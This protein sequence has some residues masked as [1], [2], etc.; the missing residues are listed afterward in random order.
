M[1]VRR[2]LV[3]FG[4]TCT[5]YRVGDSVMDDL[6]RIL[7]NVVGAP[8]RALVALDGS[9]EQTTDDAVRRALVDIGF[10][11]FRYEAAD[12]GGLEGFDAAG[13]LLAAFAER[14]LTA[15]DLVVAVGGVRLCSV[16]SLAAGLWC[17]GMSCAAI[18]Q[19]LDAM[20]TLTT[21][22]R[23]LSVGGVDEVV[24]ARPR[25]DMVV[26]DLTRV[27]GRPVEELGAGYVTMLGTA[28]AESRR[29]WD[30]FPERIEGMVA[31]DA[32]AF[33]EALCKTQGARAG[34]I[35]S[36]SPSARTALGYGA[37]TARALAACLGPGVPW[38]RLFAEGMRFEARLGH[39]VCDLDVDVIFEQDDRLEDLGVEEVPFELDADRFVSALKADRFLRS[40]RFM[41]SLPKRPGTIRL[42][43]VDDEVL[44]RH[45]EAFLASRAELLAETG[46]G[47]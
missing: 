18:P 8:K 47:N 16:V 24:S 3:N 15:D 20:C 13:R 33:T 7:K 34:A 46:A 42:S 35:R 40:N 31:G 10:E 6:P 27:L 45:A 2:Q 21:A 25:W 22:M 39:D 37:S 38:Y 41:L 43:S 1:T 14:G 28:L 30:Q 4:T 36:A 5:D 9:S 44:A 11:V 17:D 29:A 26:C 12:D 32:V 19:T 23:P